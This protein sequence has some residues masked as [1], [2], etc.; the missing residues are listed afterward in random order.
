MSNCAIVQF[1]PGA[2]NALATMKCNSN[3]RALKLQIEGEVLNEVRTIDATDNLEADFNSLVDH[4]TPT[5][6]CFFVVRLGKST[7][8][9]EY[10]FL[11]YIPARAPVRPKT[12]AASARLPIQR[13][14]ASTFTGM[15]DFFVDNANELNWAN[16]MN[17]SKKDESAYSNDELVALQERS[18]TSVAQVQLPAHDSFTWPVEDKVKQLLTQMAGKTGPRIIAAQSDGQGHGVLLQNS[19]ENLSDIPLQNPLYLAIRH[20]DSGNDIFVFVLFCPD[21][22][23][24]RDKMMCS[25][26]KHSFLV[27]CEEAGL[28]FDNKFE[29]RDSRELTDANIENLVH[30]PEVDHG[31]GEVKIYQKPRRPGRPG[32]K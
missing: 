11:V 6:P 9:P 23:K 22:A 20:N 25:T 17:I 3:L 32:R 1:S 10:L 13:Q 7:N 26:C 28:E 15:D 4:V 12:I 24:S 8:Y 19:Y 21:N 2:Q 14:I 27:A 30:P 5:E 31:F 29:I 16:Y 18:Q